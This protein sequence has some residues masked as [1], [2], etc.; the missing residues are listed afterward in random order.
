MS[1]IIMDMN[2][3]LNFANYAREQSVEMEGKMRE[4]RLHLETVV[5]SNSLQGATKAAIAQLIQQQHIP[6]ILALENAYRK[7]SA[8]ARHMIRD[9]LNFMEDNDETCIFN[10]GQIQHLRQALID[11]W[12]N[13]LDIDREYQRIYNRV[14][15]VV[16]GVGM[17]NTQPFADEF[18]RVRTD[19]DDVLGRLSAYTYDFSEIRELL[20]EINR[21][22]NRFRE[23]QLNPLTS[24][25]RQNFMADEQDFIDRMYE[26]RYGDL[27]ENLETFDE[28]GNFTGN[29]EDIEELL[30]RP[31]DQ[32]SRKELVKLYEFFMRL[33][34]GED[35][36]R[37]LSYLAN[38]VGIIS[39]TSNVDIFIFNQISEN[40]GWDGSTNEFAAWEMDPEKILAFQV[41]IQAELDNP[42]SNTD[43]SAL[44][45]RAR[46]LTNLYNLT[47]DS[48]VIIS[49]YGEKAA[50]NISLEDGDGTYRQNII[51]EIPT[52]TTHSNES[53]LQWD[54]GRVDSFESNIRRFDS[55]ETA[56]R[57]INAV[58]AD[59]HRDMLSFD[60]V[61]ESVVNNT[62]DEALGNRIGN[63]VVALGG[64]AIGAGAPVV[65]INL[66]RDE[67]R[68]R[69]A[70]ENIETSESIHYAAT[71]TEFGNTIPLNYLVDVQNGNRVIVDVQAKPG[72]TQDAVNELNRVLRNPPEGIEFDLNSLPTLDSQRSYI[73]VD[74]IVHNTDAFVEW[75]NGL[76]DN[77]IDAIVHNVGRTARQREW[78]T[79]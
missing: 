24:P 38:E 11:A 27:L 67:A 49:P 37:F 8:V 47:Q 17:P 20:S 28:D 61:W 12:R 69:E 22:L 31:F 48:T 1:N 19:T 51:M 74:D 59:I 62:A 65:T 14:P 23:I 34:T 77:Q 55:V 46:I 40:L 36:S 41:L 16:S 13:K 15:D 76:T 73:T 25:E 44:H 26:L 32:F 43:R 6:L 57:H 18:G 60:S 63:V 2:S 54:S 7:V 30:D 52:V 70:D 72:E 56:Q 29:W 66:L 71:A 3:A 21:L 50:I 53:G 64:T 33:E 68:R 35:L 39:P 75:W 79:E 58:S 4:L 45:E 42:S 5:G 78:E 9:F 10:H